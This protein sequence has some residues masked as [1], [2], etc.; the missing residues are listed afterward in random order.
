LGR[1]WQASVDCA[2]TGRRRNAPGGNSTLAIA[3]ITKPMASQSC[4]CGTSPMMKVALSVPTSGIAI[5]LM[6]LVAG[7]RS[8]A[9]PNQ[10]SCA[11]P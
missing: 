2:A 3:S 9:M 5:T 11:M 8:R 6:A 10:I 7:G 4:Q 1:W